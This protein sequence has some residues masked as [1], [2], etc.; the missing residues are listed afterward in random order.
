MALWWSA[1][2]CSEPL[3]PCAIKGDAVSMPEDICGTKRS[4]A[5]SADVFILPLPSI[6][7]IRSRPILSLELCNWIPLPPSCPKPALV[8]V[9]PIY[10][11]NGLFYMVR[12]AKKNCQIVGINQNQ[13]EMLSTLAKTIIK[14]LILR[15]RKLQ[16]PT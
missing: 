4:T 16:S 15:Q 1:S 2:R 7:L 11:S 10:G 5:I 8:L 14:M 12:L 6:P 3:P 13:T 9:G